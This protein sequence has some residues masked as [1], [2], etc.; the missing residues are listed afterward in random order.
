MDPPLLSSPCL[1]IHVVIVG[2]FRFVFGWLLF[3]LGSYNCNANMDFIIT[4]VTGERVRVR[5]LCYNCVQQLV[6]WQAAAAG[7]GQLN[8]CR[9]CDSAVRSAVCDICHARPCGDYGL[10]NPCASE[11]EQDQRIWAVTNNHEESLKC[12][13]C[14]R[15]LNRHAILTHSPLCEACRAARRVGGSSSG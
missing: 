9:S 2:C 10:C 15:W 13:D 8:L 6:V 3:L 14:Q 12:Q 4:F 5:G 11:L 7:S 1:N